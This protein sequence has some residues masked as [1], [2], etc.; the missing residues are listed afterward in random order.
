MP[1]SVRRSR[2]KV[3]NLLRRRSGGD[4][5]Q[6]IAGDLGVSVL[7]RGEAVPDELVPLPVELFARPGLSDY[8]PST[9]VGREGRCP[10]TPR[11]W[12]CCLMRSLRMSAPPG[13]TS[14]LVRGFAGIQTFLDN[15]SLTV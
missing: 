12:R 7:Y 15:T 10:I 2:S 6:N 4:R 11:S 3:A 8:W 1:R 13:A 5:Y 14:V 9:R